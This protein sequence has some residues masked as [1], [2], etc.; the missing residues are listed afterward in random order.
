MLKLWVTSAIRAG[1]KMTDKKIKFFRYEDVIQVKDLTKS[2]RD[3][4]AFN[5]LIHVH[6]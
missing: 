4:R 5:L 6:R 1:K 2:W 3:G